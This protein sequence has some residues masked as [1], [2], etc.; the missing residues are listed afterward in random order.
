MTNN[1]GDTIITNN[2]NKDEDE[3]DEDCIILPIRTT[4]EMLKNSCNKFN[5]YIDIAYRIGL[6][7]YLL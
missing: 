4:T 3:V 7:F 2:D 6:D 5:R 1:N